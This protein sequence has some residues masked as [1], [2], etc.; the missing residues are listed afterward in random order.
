MNTNELIDYQ[1]WRFQD[2]SKW[3][4][5]AWESEPDKCQWVDKDTG[6]DCLVV[7]SDSS[8]GLC[9]YV[10]VKENHPFYE[11]HYNHPDVDVH[12]GLT[13]S[14]H[15]QEDNREEGVCHITESEDKVWW[16]GFDCAHFGDFMP[17][18]A[19]LFREIGLPAREDRDSVYRDLDYVKSE[20]KSLASQLKGLQVTA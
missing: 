10:G 6:Y 2:K 14:S 18:H 8:G 12:G 17:K 1:E 5:G 15:C 3:G 9:G 7:R 4:H 19:Q 16:L 11:K 20:I 13:F